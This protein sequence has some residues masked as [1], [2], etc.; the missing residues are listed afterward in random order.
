MKLRHFLPK[1][2][3]VD[4]FCFPFFNLKGK[5]VNKGPYKEISLCKGSANIMECLMN[6]ETEAGREVEA[7]DAERLM[8]ARQLS[9]QESFPCHRLSK[10]A[11]SNFSIVSAATTFSAYV[12][13]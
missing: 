10:I 5:V 9:R 2:I 13:L 4:N 6:P 11:D 8:V 3:I 1:C 7:K 12:S